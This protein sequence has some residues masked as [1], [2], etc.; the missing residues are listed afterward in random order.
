MN[1]T[2]A[3]EHLLH[4]H[5]YFGRHTEG[6]QT[7]GRVTFQQIGIR[8]DR[9]NILISHPSLPLSAQTTED[10]RLISIK[11]NTY[12]QKIFFWKRNIQVVFITQQEFASQIKNTI[13][14]I[15]DDQAQLLG[16]SV[17]ITRYPKDILRT[18]FSRYA[19]I[20]DTGESICIGRT[21]EDAFVAAQLLEKTAK[22]WIEAQYLGGAK[23]INRIEA[24]AMQQFYLLK[25]SKE[26]QK[27]K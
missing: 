21:F 24:W 25:Y 27:N 15:L 14:P 4:A 9:N 20:L 19:T 11:G 6:Y 12:F 10:Y 2:S 16:V 22:A 26:A 18:L 17:K 1:L 7:W 13:P 3:Q 8:V 5:Q 23:S